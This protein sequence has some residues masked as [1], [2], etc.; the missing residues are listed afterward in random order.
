MKPTQKWAGLPETERGESPAAET[1]TTTNT[2]SIGI[3]AESAAV[4][5]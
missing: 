1:A 5:C 4:L 2:D 3:A